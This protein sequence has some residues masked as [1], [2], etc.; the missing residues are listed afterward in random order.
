MA[1]G[2]RINKTLSSKWD[3][4]CDVY[5]GTRDEMTGSSSDDWILLAL[6]LQP[7]L[8]TLSHNTIAIPHI[9]ETLLTLI[10]SVLHS[11]FT[12]IAPS[13]IALVHTL[14]YCTRKSSITSPIYDC[15]T[16]HTHS[17]SHKSQSQS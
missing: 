14:H 16:N 11:Q 4:Y 10:L 8:I 12:V 3:L 5:G 2:T 9:V 15:L 1:L 6:W 7:L 13:L 17:L